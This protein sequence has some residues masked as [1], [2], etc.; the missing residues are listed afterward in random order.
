MGAV[1]G[2]QTGLAI[3][4]IAT[5]KPPRMPPSRYP[6]TGT[7]AAVC[8]QV[9]VAVATN[10]RRRNAVRLTVPS[11]VIGSVPAPTPGPNRSNVLA[12]RA[13]LLVRINGSALGWD[14]S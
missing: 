8:D 9:Q 6:P 12:L 3:V 13:G 10:R 1:T 7:P 5:T 14:V 2:A 11:M 4:M